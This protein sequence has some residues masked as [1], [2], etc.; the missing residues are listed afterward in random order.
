MEAFLAFYLQAQIELIQGS[1]LENGFIRIICHE[2]KFIFYR[3][4][5]FT[6]FRFCSHINAQKRLYI[7]VSMAV[8]SHL[9]PCGKKVQKMR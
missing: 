8:G 6:C 2:I 1:N 3:F 5:V 7:R 4:F 9:F